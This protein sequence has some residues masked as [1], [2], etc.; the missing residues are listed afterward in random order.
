MIVF[1]IVVAVLVALFAVIFSLSATFTI[2]YDKGW[3][4]KIKVLFIEKDISLTSLLTL[5][6][7]P[8]KKAQDMAEEA[9]DKAKNK[10]KNKDKV[11]DSA[12]SIVDV[13]KTESESDKSAED[14]SPDKNADNK[15][16]Q[17][18]KPN[19][20]KKM[21]DEDGIVGILSFVSN[22]LETA[23]SAVLTLIRGLHIYSLYVM[24]LVGGSDAAV[25]AQSYG[26]LC[27]YYYPVKGLILNGMKV[28][29]YDDYIQPDFIAESTE[30]QF[31]FIGSISVGLLLRVVLKA[32]F[33]FLKNLIKNK[34]GD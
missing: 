2:V 19:P 7:F 4:T 18:S 28:D 10:K 29:N 26:T 5:I 15:P 30:A 25:I 8:E 33:I 34:K 27:S 9:E 20:I 23:N 3:S 6:L 14:T 17:K 1:L 21:W 24:I 22:L 31:Q 32:G 12:E 11:K 16:A 13:T